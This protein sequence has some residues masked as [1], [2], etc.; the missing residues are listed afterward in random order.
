[1]STYPLARVLPRLLPWEEASGTREWSFLGSGYLLQNLGP[2]PVN[3]EL[4]T[5]VLY[6][7]KDLLPPKPETLFRGHRHRLDLR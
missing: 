6:W 1:M 2:I 4:S 3:D 7:M 5:L